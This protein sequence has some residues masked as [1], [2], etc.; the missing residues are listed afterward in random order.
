MPSPSRSRTRGSPVAPA[1]RCIPRRI[2]IHLEVEVVGL[3]FGVRGAVAGGR[4][5]AGVLKAQKAEL[6]EPV[7]EF[8]E[9]GLHIAVARKEPI[10]QF[11]DLVEDFVGFGEEVVDRAEKLV[12]SAGILREGLGGAGIAVEGHA[13]NLERHRESE[14]DLLAGGHER[15][16]LGAFEPVGHGIGALLEDGQ[17]FY[18]RFGEEIEGELVG[19][20]ADRLVAVFPEAGYLPADLTHLGGKRNLLHLRPVDHGVESVLDIRGAGIQH[21]GRGLGAFPL[22]RGACVGVRLVGEREAGP[23][24]NTVFEVENGRE[25]LLQE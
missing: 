8:I 23:G 12:E 21:I 3:E 4:L 16:A 15:F 25:K 1:P 10:E 11:E 6:A 7:D 13:G 24:K 22:G 18:A 20:E 9:T 17:L 5:R 2:R 14:G 19:L